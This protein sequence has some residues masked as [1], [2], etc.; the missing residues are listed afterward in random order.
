[1]RGVTRESVTRVLGCAI[2]TPKFFAPLPLHA[3]AYIRT[4]ACMYIR[5][6]DVIHARRPPLVSVAPLLQRWPTQRC[7]FL[8]NRGDLP[9]SLK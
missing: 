3:R 9:S 7:G 8:T 6:Y 5:M 4:N 1:M 2:S